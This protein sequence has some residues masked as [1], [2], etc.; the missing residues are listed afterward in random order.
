MAEQP[1]TAP[2]NLNPKLPNR[3]YA[4]A[5][6]SAVVFHIPVVPKMYVMCAALPARVVMRAMHR[7]GLG[8]AV[9]P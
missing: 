3:G 2:S 4:H 1:G 7:F 5:T 8:G 6:L 9:L